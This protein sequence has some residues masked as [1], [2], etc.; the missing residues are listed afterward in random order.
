MRH[1]VEGEVEADVGAGKCPCFFER[2]H[3]RHHHE[4]A[5]LVAVGWRTGGERKVVAPERV[6]REIADHRAGLHAEQR[7]S[8]DPQHVTDRDARRHSR[9]HRRQLLFGFGVVTGGPHRVAQRG[10]ERLEHGTERGQM[11]VDPALRPHGLDGGRLERR[12]ETGLADDERLRGLDELLELLPVGRVDRRLGTTLERDPL[13]RLTRD[14][15]V[16]RTGRRQH[17]HHLTDVDL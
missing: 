2:V 14:L 16:D 7:R 4:Q 13:R 6:L 3:V 8:E 15:P 5:G 9:D 11:E 10:G 1:L 17:L 12:V